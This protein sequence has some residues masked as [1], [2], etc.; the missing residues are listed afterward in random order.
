[1][2]LRGRTV[3]VWTLPPG[4]VPSR[5]DLA[6]LDGVERRRADELPDARRTG[7][8]LGRS[9]LRGAVAS[10][11]GTDPAAV[12]LD[13]TCSC[14]GLHGRPRLDVPGAPSLHLGV[15]RSG[16]RVAVA[17]ARHP[18][19]VDVV[20]VEAVRPSLAQVA[21][22]PAEQDA[23]RR[24]G[25]N[26]AD[27]ARAWARTEAALKAAGTGL[28]TDPASVDVRGRRTRVG[29][30]DVLLRDVPCDPGAAVAVAC[31]L[32]RTAGP[33]WAP[34]ASGAA[35]APWVRLRLVTHDGARLLA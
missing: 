9:L 25:G 34:S 19:G 16:P 29:A 17:L 8:V 15:S 18:V 24:A 33:R 30:S 26:V 14:G 28:R 2:E 10:V 27:L 23:W 7:F 12:P 13:S 5:A 11:L 21:L 1:M 3:E 4:A 35:W 6:R 22:G 31:A 20:A 32:R